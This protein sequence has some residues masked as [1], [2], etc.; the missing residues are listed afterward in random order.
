MKSL[1]TPEEKKRILKIIEERKKM[2]P[3]ERFKIMQ[4][5]IFDLGRPTNSVKLVKKWR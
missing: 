5:N 4:S 2:S 3:E 1:V